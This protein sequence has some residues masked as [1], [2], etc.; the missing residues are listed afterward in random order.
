MFAFQ[1]VLTSLELLT[2]G[3]IEANRHS[4]KPSIM[5]SSALFIKPEMIKRLHQA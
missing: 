5:N 3:L 4:K 1:A 2:I